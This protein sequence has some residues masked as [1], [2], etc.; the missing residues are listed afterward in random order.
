M[1][2]WVYRSGVQSRENTALGSGVLDWEGAVLCWGAAGEARRCRAGVRGCRAG[3]RGAAAPGAALRDAGPGR[4]R[5]PRPTG[6]TPP[7]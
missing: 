7:I 4:P 1:Q 2:A 5:W 6:R 3:V